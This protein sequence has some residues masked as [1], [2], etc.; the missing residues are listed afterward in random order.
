MDVEL[1][2]VGQVVVDDQRNLRDVQASSPHVCRDQDPAETQEGGERERESGHPT[3]RGPVRLG[4]SHGL[5]ASPGSGSEL[6]HDGL[7]LLLRHVSV[8]GGHGEV[9]LPHLL[10]QPVHLE[11]TRTQTHAQ[12]VS[13]NDVQL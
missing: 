8:H 11:H 10:R 13:R 9:G 1:S 3:P 7:S 2:V 12:S 5:C 6:L 4:R